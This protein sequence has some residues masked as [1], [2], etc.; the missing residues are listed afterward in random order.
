DLYLRLIGHGG[1]AYFIRRFQ[2]GNTEI[3][4]E[5][6]RQTHPG[7][8]GH[9]IPD[10]ARARFGASA[11]LG[12]FGYW[13]EHGRHEQAEDIAAWYWRLMRPILFEDID[14]DSP[15]GR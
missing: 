3:L 9:V 1:S 2:A 14:D 5:Y 12:L 11:T 8:T 13:L 10:E 15:S 7:G 6:W 4:H